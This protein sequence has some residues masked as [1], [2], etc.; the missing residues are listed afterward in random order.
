MSAHKDLD[1]LLMVATDGIATLEAL[2]LP[3]PS[4]TETDWLICPEP[5][6]KDVIESPQLYR[7]EGDQ[8]LV[9]KP[10]GGWERKI[11]DNGLFLARPGIYFPLNPTEKDIKRIRARGLGRNAVWDNWD[12][13]VRAYEEGEPGIQIQGLTLFRGIKTSITRSGSKDFTYKRSDQ[14]GTWVTRPVDMTF[15]PLPKREA[16][17]GD[18]GRLT[19]RK[20]DGLESAAYNKG[21]LSPDALALIQQGI[22]AAEQPDGGDLTNYGEIDE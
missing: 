1:N 15:S 3:K 20:L 22:E 9:N 7:R 17:I 14:Y 8:W 12:K 18:N 6:P 21:I 13:I 19:L 2:D 10:L 16:K 4:N 11:L 5:N